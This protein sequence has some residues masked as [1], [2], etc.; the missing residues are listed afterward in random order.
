MSGSALA[1]IFGGILVQFIGYWAISIAALVIAVI[2]LMMFII[3]EK[4]AVPADQLEHAMP[5][6]EL[7]AS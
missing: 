2:G 1:P 4:Q 5:S 3:A 6:G 7:K